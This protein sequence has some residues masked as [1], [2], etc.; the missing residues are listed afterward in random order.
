MKNIRK[1]GMQV[2]KKVAGIRP[3][4]SPNCW[5]KEKTETAYL[6]SH[7]SNNFR[8]GAKHFQGHK[9]FFGFPSSSFCQLHGK[10]NPAKGDEMGGLRTGTGGL[11]EHRAHEDA[12]RT[13]Q[14]TGYNQTRNEQF[15]QRPE[16]PNPA[17]IHLPRR[18]SRVR[19]HT[20]LRQIKS[21]VALSW[22]PSLI[23]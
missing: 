11:S 16:L 9:N 19:Q 1:P 21:S 14:R 23:T 7:F 15:V 18:Y 3:V 20:R 17:W 5:K 12:F 8:S 13:M 22:R 10:W 4:R 6:Q 2:Y